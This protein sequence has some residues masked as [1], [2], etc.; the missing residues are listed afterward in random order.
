MNARDKARAAKLQRF[1]EASFNIEAD[2]RGYVKR[3][4][5]L[6]VFPARKALEMETKLRDR[7]LHMIEEPAH[8]VNDLA[9]V[10][11][12]IDAAN[13]LQTMRELHEHDMSKLEGEAAE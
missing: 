6:M 9:T 8:A 1:N 2:R 5:S 7:G 13:W 10:R 12:M 3:T 11:A 4:P